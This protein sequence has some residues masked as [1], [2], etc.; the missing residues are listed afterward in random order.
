VSQLHHLGSPALKGH[1]GAVESV[2]FSPDSKHIV[3][4]SDDKTLKIWDAATGQENLTLKGHTGL[5]TGVAV[6]SDAKLI[7]SC[8]RDGAVKVWDAATGQNTLTLK[9]VG[10][11][12]AFSPDAKSFV[13]ASSVYRRGSQRVDDTLEVWDAATGR[14]TLILRGHTGTIYSV[15]FSPDGKRIASGSGDKT[16]KIWDAATGQETLTLKAHTGAVTSVAFSR[17]GQRIASGSDNTI[18]IWDASAAANRFILDPQELNNRSWLVVRK[19][20]AE[21]AEYRRALLLAQEACRLEPEDANLLNT[22][23]VAEYRTGQF[24]QAL[25]TLSRSKDLNTRERKGDIHLLRVAVLDGRPRGR[26]VNSNPSRRAV[27]ST[28]VG[29]P[30]GAPR[31]T[32]RCNASISPEVNAWFTHASQSGPRGNGP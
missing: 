19:A 22:R 2:A 26:S 25:R 31:S 13:T 30:Y 16:V 20:I 4:G 8:S 23:G 6:G 7:A 18:R 28:Q 24:Q 1:T 11:C 10:Q 27:F 3:S 21:P 5:V 12:V 14:Q 32:Q 15:A 29:G 17:D 9:D